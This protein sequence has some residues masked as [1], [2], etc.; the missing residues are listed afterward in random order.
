MFSSIIPIKTIFK[1]GRQIVVKLELPYLLAFEQVDFY[2]F[3]NLQFN[4]LGGGT[5][6]ALA[7]PIFT[8]NARPSFAVTCTELIFNVLCYC[9][10]ICFRFERF[11]CA[12][13]R[14][15]L[16]L[17]SH[18]SH[19]YSLKFLIGCLKYLIF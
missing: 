9:Q 18:F 15:A 2:Q 4:E 19:I 14:S 12:L 8:D 3:T 16:L 13:F 6:T 10:K 1:R 17:V 11:L 5:V 7:R